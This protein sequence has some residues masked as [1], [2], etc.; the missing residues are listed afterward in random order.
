MKKELIILSGFLG[1]GKTTILL[2]LLA[3]NA[4]KKIAVIV[5]DFGQTAVDATILE[6]EQV[7]EKIYE[8]GGGSVFCSCLSE[9]LV[10]TLFAIAK[11]DFDLVILEASGMSDPSI[12]NSMLSLAK[13]DTYFTHSLT[14][15]TFDA[16]KSL[17]LAKVLLVIERQ[18]TS[19]NIVIL[20]KADKYSEEELNTAI[21]FIQEKE[22]AV[23]II[24]SYNGE[25]S[26]DNISC[27][28]DL[29]YFSMG[30]NKPDN[31]LDS[32]E[33]EEVSY[34]LD[35]LLQ[36]FQDNNILRVKGYI[37]TSDGVWFISDTGTDYYKEK[38]TELKV[39]LTIIC[40]QGTANYIK[41]I[42]NS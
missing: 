19:A 29:P 42:I 14:L 7:R 35:E 1:S 2:S 23:P 26:L 21:K 37:K 39:P 24:K 40:M 33:L 16:I 25:F 32:F 31:R 38:S 15:C 22:P 10:K 5:N 4:G 41:K 3:K 17:K 12:I 9:T 18:L 6:K 8:I 27:R 36:K 30:L 11:E 28:F 20:T 13:L 34:T